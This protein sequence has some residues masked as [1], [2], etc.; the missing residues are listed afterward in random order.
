M[1]AANDLT[2]AALRRWEE[3]EPE[4]CKRAG[5]SSRAM[6]REVFELAYLYGHID[7][8]ADEREAIADRRERA[9]AALAGDAQ[10]DTEL[11]HENHSMG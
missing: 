8:L 9:L 7:A 5:P 4:W 1:S 6:V 2:V 11:S 3:D 10:S